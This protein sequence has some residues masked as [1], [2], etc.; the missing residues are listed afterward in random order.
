MTSPEKSFPRCLFNLFA[1]N[2]PMRN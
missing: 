2:E 1:M